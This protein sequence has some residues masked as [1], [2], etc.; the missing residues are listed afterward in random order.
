MRC[1]IAAVVIFL[2]MLMQLQVSAQENTFINYRYADGF[3]NSQLTD[4]T[5]DEYGVLWFVGLTGSLYT[6]D[7][8]EFRKFPLPPHVFTNNIYRISASRSQH[9]IYLITDRGILKFDGSNFTLLEGTLHTAWSYGTRLLRDKLDVLWLLDKEGSLFS[10]RED[11][12]RQI[13][14]LNASFS[15]MT[16]TDEGSIALYESDGA[17]TYVNPETAEVTNQTQLKSIDGGA[18]K[19]TAFRADSLLVFCEKGIYSVSGGAVK[20]ISDHG[21]ASIRNITKDREGNLWILSV[22][23]LYRLRGSTLT[24]ITGEQGLTDNHV[25]QINTD[26]HSN[27]WVMSDNEGVYQHRFKP[28][29]TINLPGA[30][31]VSSILPITED[32]IYITTFGQGVFVKGKNGIYQPRAL[33]PLKGVLLIGIAPYQGG[34]LF[35]TDGKGLFHFANGKLQSVT[36]PQEALYIRCV[37]QTPEIF[38]GTQSGV[39]R[40]NRFR[41]DPINV[42]LQ[43]VNVI[44]STRSGELLI[45]TQ[46]NGMFRMKDGKLTAWDQEFYQSTAINFFTID[47]LDNVWVSSNRDHIS[48]YAKDLS[49]KR[50][51]QLPSYV[52]SVTSLEIVDPN[53]IIISADDNFYLLGVNGNLEVTSLE[54]LTKTEGVTPGELVLGGSLKKGNLIWYSS[55]SGAYR[56]DTKKLTLRFNDIPLAFITKVDTNIYDSLGENTT[57]KAGLF[58]LPVKL[59]LTHNSNAVTFEYRATDLSNPDRLRY[60]YKLTGL[61]QD[62]SAF[63]KDRRITFTNLDRGHYTFEVQALSANGIF[64]PVASYSFTVLPAFWQTWWFTSTGAVLVIS[65]VFFLYHVLSQRRINRYKH[66]EQIRQN[67]A[68]KIRQQMSMDFHDELGNKL[69]GILSYA[70]ALRV[71]SKDQNTPLLEYIESSAQAVYHGTRDFIWSINLESNNLQEVLIYLR[72]FGVKFFDKHGIDFDFDANLQNPILNRMLPE[73][74]NRQLV[75]IFKEAMTNVYK[76]SKCTK[77]VLGVNVNGKRTTIFLKDDGRGI[78][79]AVQSG[80]GIRNMKLRAK[81]LNADIDIS[82]NTKGTTISVSFNT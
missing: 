58:Q 29:Q 19:A 36:G 74:N 39:F 44:R 23:K 46:H 20:K 67:E 62:W 65:L 12:L 49:L 47:S 18:V 57:E 8:Y 15:W 33:D 45:G 28:F 78:Q 66:E 48:V 38:V 5:E 32:S 9:A 82:S 63:S 53:R 35:G 16:Q 56:L 3:D 11:T 25:V 60:R 40:L 61:D 14:N 51:I 59:E 30:L 27:L 34:V 76:H 43:D 80:N 6:F 31:T 13:K 68:Q 1:V 24:R 73:G 71:Q 2:A 41:L 37:A 42:D 7:G 69:A 21:F 10:L 64:S 52:G 75:L 79:E 77:V 26:R 81:K 72:D 50:R 54:V 4:M 70:S 55:S 17:T 22:L